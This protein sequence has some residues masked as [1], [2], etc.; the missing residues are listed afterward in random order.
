MAH[1]HMAGYTKNGSCELAAVADLSRPNAEAFIQEHNPQAAI[2]EDYMEMM[3]VAK[4]D[5]VSVCLWPHL[6]AQVVCDIAPLGC[7]A[8]HCEKPMDIHWDASLRMVEACRANK[9]QLTVNHQRRYNKPFLKAKRMID[10]GTIGKVLR[11]E[12][13]WHN[14]FDAGTHWLDMMFYFNNDEDVEWVLGQIDIRNA[15]RSFGALQAGHGL[16]TYRFKNGVR[17][18]Y[19]SG[20]N[21]EDVGCMIRVIG[22]KGVVEIHGTQPWLRFLLYDQTGW[23]LDDTKESIHD[24][25]AIYRGIDNLIECL[26][27]G[28]KPLLSGDNALRTTEIIFATHES[29]RRRARVELPLPAMKSP[30]L[31]MVDAGELKLES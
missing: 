27:T 5:I 9:V 14:L 11:M 29:S 25:A 30:L 17:A 3:R 18:T 23:Q 26:K 7:R 21:H 13:G 4:P 10:E 16:V 1:R 6:H 2:F 20:L 12:S 24:D 8:I 15:K 19:H 22:D 28:A 31:E